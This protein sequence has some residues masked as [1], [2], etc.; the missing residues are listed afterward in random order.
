M[1]ELLPLFGDAPKDNPAMVEAL[2]SGDAETAPNYAR[3]TDDA[4]KTVRT[5]APKA[6]MPPRGSRE[7]GMIDGAALVQGPTMNATDGGQTNWTREV[8][9]DQLP[10]ALKG[11]P[12]AEANPQAPRPTRRNP[13]TGEIEPRAAVLG[14][15]LRERMDREIAQADRPQ[16]RATA[17]SKRRARARRVAERKLRERVQGRGDTFV[18]KG[19]MVDPVKAE[20]K[21]LQ[22][23]G[24]TLPTQGW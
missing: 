20:V 15:S 7:L 18:P 22:A 1:A 21:R 13:A 19:R 14:G 16:P 11:A 24:S 9:A 12:M 5:R 6:A 8:P 2:R 17:S 3:A 23:K 10:N 4:A